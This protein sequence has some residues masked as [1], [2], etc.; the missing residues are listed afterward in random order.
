MR[1]RKRELLGL[2]AAACAG[3]LAV[4]YLASPESP[5]QVSGFREAE[6][7]WAMEDE[8]TESGEPP[9]GAAAT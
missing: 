1:N 2:L 4:L 3:L 5:A 7:L 8:R 9:H 6:E